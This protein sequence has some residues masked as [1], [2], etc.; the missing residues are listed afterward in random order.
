MKRRILIDCDGVIT[1]YASASFRKANELAGTS[2]THDDCTGWDPLKRPEFQHIED[3]VW[4]WIR[5]PG[6]A[7]DE[8]KLYD[9]ALEGVRS[10][11]KF[12]IENDLLFRVLTSPAETPTFCSDRWRAFDRDFGIHRHDIIFAHDKGGYNGI[13]LIDDKVENIQEWIAEHGRKKVVAFL[14]DRPWNRAANFSH[15]KVIRT[16]DWNLVIEKLKVLV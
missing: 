1:D 16:N 8:L 15:P 2:F 7:H 14:W 3:A 9:G 4:N 10:L 11:Q 6:W 13:C 5:K 12:A